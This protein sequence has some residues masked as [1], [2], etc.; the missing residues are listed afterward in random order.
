RRREGSERAPASREA[1]CDRCGDECG[2]DETPPPIAPSR[3]ARGQ[4]RRI[5]CQA[6]G[7]AGALNE[8]RCAPLLGGREQNV[9]RIRADRLQRLET[10][11][12]PDAFDMART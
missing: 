1:D 9:D 12:R 5:T 8:E 7:E 11:V 3:G 2:E 4:M 6:G 10:V